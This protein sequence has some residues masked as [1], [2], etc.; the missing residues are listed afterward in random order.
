ASENNPSPAA[1][2]E[3]GPTSDSSRVPTPQEGASDE[4]PSDLQFDWDEFE[5]SPM[6]ESLHRLCKRFSSSSPEEK[7]D[8]ATFIARNQLYM[9]M[10][11]YMESEETGCDQ[12]M[13]GVFWECKGDYNNCLNVF[14]AKLNESQ[15][16]DSEELPLDKVKALRGIRTIVA[17]LIDMLDLRRWLP[18]HFVALTNVLVKQFQPKEQGTSSKVK[19]YT[20]P[21]EAID[22]FQVLLQRLDLVHDMKL[23]MPFG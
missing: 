19:K 7:C 16:Q 10:E 2:A 23:K 18:Y 4:K 3:P 13:C 20:V 15:I 1:E 8:M 6:K 22:I 21:G 12:L 5:S 17:D 9:M 11:H 14:L